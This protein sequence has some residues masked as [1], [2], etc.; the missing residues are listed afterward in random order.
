LDPSLDIFESMGLHRTLRA[1]TQATVAVDRYLKNGSPP[2]DQPELLGLRNRAQWLALNLQRGSSG[3]DAVKGIAEK[4]ELVFNILKIS[5]LIYNNLV[6]FPLP[7]VSGVDTRLALS[8]KTS[9]EAALLE[10]P[11][12]W[13]VHPKLLLWALMLGGISDSKDLERPWFLEKF[14][15]LLADQ[16]AECCK[17]SQVENLLTSCMWLGGILSDEGITFWADSRNRIVI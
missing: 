10:W 17:W 3:W 11:T 15:D 8:L 16:F 13:E 2:G 12:L 14:G 6:L 5:L 7:P 4:D 9:I 1:V